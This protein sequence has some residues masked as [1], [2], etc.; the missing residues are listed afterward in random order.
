[1]CGQALT[2]DGSSYYSCRENYIV[3]YLR[4]RNSGLYGATAATG[5]K[6]PFGK[7]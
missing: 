1:L 3:V 7:K 2:W 5:V 6:P 4:G